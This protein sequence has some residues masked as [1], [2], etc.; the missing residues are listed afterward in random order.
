EQEPVKGK[1]TWLEKGFAMTDSLLKWCEANKMYL[2]LDLHAAPGGQGNDFNIS[3]RN[4]Q[5]ASLWESEENQRKMIS[6]WRK[7]A[8]RYKDEPWIGAYDI[9]NEPNYGFADPEND[10]NGIKEKGNAPLRKLMV[11]VTAAIRETDKNHIVIIEGNGWGNNYS[12][13]LPAWDTNMV[14][15]FHK[16]WNNNT[17]GDIS[18][19]L[20]LREKY[21]MPLW[22]GESGENSNVW[23]ADA[24]HLAESNGI[25]WAFWP[26]KK[27]GFNNPLQVVANPGYSKVVEYLHGRGE[28]PSAADAK[29]ALM[30]L[31]QHDIQFENNIVHSDVVDAML[32]QPT[33]EVAV[34]FKNHR[35]KSATTTIA[36]VDYDMGRHT[37]FDVNSANYHVSTGGE[38]TLWNDGLTYRNDGVDIGVEKSG[39]TQTFYVDKV[40][41]GEWL[42]YTVVVEKP[43]DYQ[44]QAKVKTEKNNAAITV[45]VNNDIV[46]EATAISS[47]PSKW[48]IQNLTPVT[49]T[50]GTNILRVK[51][52][53]GGYQLSALIFRKL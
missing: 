7:L 27:I 39:K 18:A 9:I 6:L 34:P 36:A 16:Y 32:R 46:K 42:Q 21:N 43:G 3:D 31:A 12:G 33:S 35:L 22:L 10:K 13:I 15:S 19:A 53:E 28:R 45:I 5:L 23:F 11:D 41:G 38:R 49:L 26:L 2:I 25:G 20:Q 47:S 1:D 50:K 44:L 14:L 48:S 24:I 52:V 29:K 37:Y 17:Q 8:D 4:P 51:A 30:K 40:E